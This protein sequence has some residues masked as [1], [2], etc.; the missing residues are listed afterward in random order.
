MIAFVA[1]QGCILAT[2]WVRNP[3]FTRGLMLLRQV[4]KREGIT[5]G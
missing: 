4:T 5:V 2:L 1:F 3:S